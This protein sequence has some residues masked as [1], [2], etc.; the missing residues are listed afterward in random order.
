[1]S[2]IRGC[3][4]IFVGLLIIGILAQLLGKIIAAVIMIIALVIALGAFVYLV[5]VEAQKK[6]TSGDDQQ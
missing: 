2:F 1:M 6:R 3:L 5:N 4:G